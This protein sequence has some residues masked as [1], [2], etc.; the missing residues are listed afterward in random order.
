MLWPP[1][2]IPVATISNKCLLVFFLGFPPNTLGNWDLVTL[3]EICS[4]PFH[5]PLLL[6]YHKLKIKDYFLKVYIM[7]WL[8][9]VFVAVWAFSSCAARGLLSRHSAQA[10]HC[11]GCSCC[12]AQALECVCRLSSYGSQA[13]EHRL[14]IVPQVLS[15]YTV[16][17][18]FLD[19]GL[20]PCLLHWQADPLPLS[21]QGSPNLSSIELIFFKKLI[22]VIIIFSF[23]SDQSLSRVR[24]FATPWIAARQASLSITNSRSSLRLTSIESVMLS[25]HLILCRSLMKTLLLLVAPCGVWDHSSLTRNQTCAPCLGSTDS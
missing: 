17:G 3:N 11:D 10:S 13:L 1:A 20:N 19:Q 12:G 8:C 22:F 24:L 18:I 16:C 7:F 4:W 6:I 23:R 15:C 25:S 2:V 9:W 14:N 5:L 21:H